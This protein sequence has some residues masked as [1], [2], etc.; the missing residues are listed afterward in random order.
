M[1]GAFR[2]WLSRLGQPGEVGPADEAS[3][4]PSL[5]RIA[6]CSER[7]VVRVSGTVEALEVKQRAASRWLEAQLFDGTAPL[8]LVWMGRQEVPGIEVGRRMV[9]EGRV[10]KDEAGRCRIMNP[11]YTLL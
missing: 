9:V 3:P 4:D 1:P 6:E 2:K 7:Q 10:S 8:T 11:M 5:A